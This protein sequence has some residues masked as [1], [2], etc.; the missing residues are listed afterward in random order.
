MNKV[1]TIPWRIVPNSNENWTYGI[2]NNA[3]GIKGLQKKDTNSF[4]GS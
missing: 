1:Q 2:K 3:F 4:L